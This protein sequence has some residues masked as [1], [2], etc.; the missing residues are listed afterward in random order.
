MNRIRLT[1]THNYS[2]KIASAVSFEWCQH[3]DPS[4]LFTAHDYSLK[5][6]SPISFDSVN[7]H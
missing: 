1:A 3:F 2:F 7:D 4:G 6:A 5:I